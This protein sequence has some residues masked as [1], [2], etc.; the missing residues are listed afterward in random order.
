M[1]AFWVVK[2]LDVIEHVATSILPRAVDLSLD[3][4]PLQQ[5][6]EAFRHSIVVTIAASTHAAQQVVGFQKTLPIAAAELTALVR[7]DHH[8]LLWLTPPNRHQ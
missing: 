3:P 5:L 2:H 6:E 1:S 7:V 4:L 8:F